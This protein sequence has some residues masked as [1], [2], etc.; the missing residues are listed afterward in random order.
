MS[1]SSIYT[2][3]SITTTVAPGNVVPLGSTIRRFGCNVA[4]DE[5]SITV[6][7]KGYFAVTANATVT[8]SSVGNV[9]ITM[10]K[11]GVV[12]TGASGINSVST[13]GNTVTVPIT[14]I[15]RN[16]CDCDSSNISFT[17]DT[18]TSNVVNFV[19]SVVKL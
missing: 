5:N 6:K 16:T 10:L 2:V 9:G 11:D 19:V 17:L 14:A 13:V 3:N 8:P 15:I 1:K 18:T 12:V 7:G 4:Q